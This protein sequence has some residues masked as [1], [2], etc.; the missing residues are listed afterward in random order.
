[1]RKIIQ[2]SDDTSSSQQHF[3]SQLLLRIKIDIFEISKEIL[4]NPVFL[5]NFVLIEYDLNRNIADHFH[6][7]NSIFI[8]KERYFSFLYIKENTYSFIQSL[9]FSLIYRSVTLML[10]FVDCGVTMSVLTLFELKIIG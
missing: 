10:L 4:F 6:S 3:P 8:L 2:K 9:L 1:M 5:G 7:E